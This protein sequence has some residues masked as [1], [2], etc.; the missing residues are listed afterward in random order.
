MEGAWM[1][2]SV[3]SVFSQDFEGDW[4]DWVNFMGWVSELLPIECYDANMFVEDA[5]SLFRRAILLR[6]LLWMLEEMLKEMLYPFYLLL[7]PT[8]PPPIPSIIL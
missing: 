8:S 3:L 7:L 1:E 2:L 4:F 6:G 5:A